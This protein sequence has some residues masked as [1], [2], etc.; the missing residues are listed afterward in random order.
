MSI[1]HALLA[2][3]ESRPGYGLQLKNEFE[4]WTGEVWPLNVG[5]VYTTLRRL[6][7]DG[8][9]D[10]EG[11]V[12]ERQRLYALS[13][14]G[15]E[16]LERWLT[17]PA[18]DRGPPR[19]ELVIKVLMSLMVDSVATSELVQVHRRSLMVELQQYTR[20]KSCIDAD[21]L[22]GLLV[23]DAQ[24]FR[25]EAMARWLD[26]CEARIESGVRLAGRERH[27]S[28]VEQAVGSDSDDIEQGRS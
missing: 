11:V 5:Q 15:R 18:A 9:V 25:V 16:E 17:T 4:A 21:D 3:L 12:D 6:E 22:A 28:E 10:A 8:L 27:R 14:T 20:L 13:E 7:R 1:P 24:I 23:L 2:L 26:L 19:D